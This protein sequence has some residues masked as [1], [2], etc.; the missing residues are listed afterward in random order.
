MQLFL[1]HGS[2]M[3]QEP[4]KHG[5]ETVVASLSPNITEKYLPQQHVHGYAGQRH[6]QP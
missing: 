6:W 1:H 3:T 5:N 2:E 4:Q